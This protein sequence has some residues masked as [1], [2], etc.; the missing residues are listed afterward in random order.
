MQNYRPKSFPGIFT[1]LPVSHLLVTIALFNFS[2]KVFDAAQLDNIAFPFVD[3]SIN[4][5]TKRH[6]AFAHAPFAKLTASALS[7]PRDEYLADNSSGPDSFESSSRSQSPPSR[8]R[9]TRFI[10][11]RANCPPSNVRELT[12]FLLEP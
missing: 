8:H 7:S 4:R 12:Q 6:E 3:K 5:L 9:L 11:P 1:V 10:H 2:F